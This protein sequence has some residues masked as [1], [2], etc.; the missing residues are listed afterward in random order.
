L[1]L[2][3]RL[4]DG[5]HGLW[6]RLARRGNEDAFRRL[7][8]ELYDPVAS[9]IAARTRNSHDAEDQTSGSWNGSRDSRPAGDRS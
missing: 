4:R 5:R 3:R 1:D 8:G 9:Y 6:L 2:K 7:Y